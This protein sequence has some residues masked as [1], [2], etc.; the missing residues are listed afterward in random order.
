MSSS[1]PG[2]YFGQ[3][4]VTISTNHIIAL[5]FRKPP[6]TKPF[7]VLYWASFASDEQP[8]LATPQCM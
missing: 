3:E 7:V 2:M 6:M 1:H 4:Y 8:P 5:P